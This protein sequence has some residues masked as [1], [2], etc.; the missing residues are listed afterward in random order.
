[1]EVSSANLKMM[2]VQCFAM[3]SCVNREYSK[4]LRMQLYGAPVLIV[5]VEGRQLP[6]LTTWGLLVRKSKIQL[7]SCVFNPK[8]FSF[9]ISL[10]G[11]IALKAEL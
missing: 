11:I 4:G 9:V 3:Q 8:S 2:L 7:H 6:I 5:S 1:M 10:T